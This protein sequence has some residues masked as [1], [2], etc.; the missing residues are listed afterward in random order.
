MSKSK[1][2]PRRPRDWSASEKLEVVLEASRL[3]DDEL[4]KHLR[5]KG[6]H[7]S[8]LQEWRRQAE[9]G[10]GGAPASGDKKLRKESQ[11]GSKEL[12]RK[13]RAR[14]E[15]AALLVLA[16]KARALWGDEGENT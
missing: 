11:S 6:L 14:A 3:N 7:E 13:E 4:G 1:N 15:A 5:E 2:R 8:H 9:G 12:G 16:K 10:L